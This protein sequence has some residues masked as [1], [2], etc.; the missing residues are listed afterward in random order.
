MLMPFF[1][2]KAISSSNLFS[3]AF[4]E[5]TVAVTATALRAKNA[6][7]PP[8]AAT[9]AISEVARGMAT[10]R[11]ACVR[12]KVQRVVSRCGRYDRIKS[13]ETSSQAVEA[14]PAPRDEAH[15]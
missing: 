10:C 4:E 13:R 12:I 9:W 5:A 15:L 14:F 1:F 11:L 8:P 3:I 2:A 7:M 6:V